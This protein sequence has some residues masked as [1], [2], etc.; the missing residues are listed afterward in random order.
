MAQD[1]TR[2]VSVHTRIVL[3]DGDLCEVTIKDA[4]PVERRGVPHELSISMVGMRT[5][6]LLP[7]A[8]CLLERRAR[9]KVSAPAVYW[10]I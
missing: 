8:N 9:G 1:S 6:R 5:A 7:L 2:V 3:T 4:V 10:Q